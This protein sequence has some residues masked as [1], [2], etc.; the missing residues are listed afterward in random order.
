M[1]NVSV[2]DLRKHLAEGIHVGNDAPSFGDCYRYDGIKFEE[3]DDGVAIERTKGFSDYDEGGSS[4][5][6]HGRWT[7]LLLTE[8]VDATLA[9]LIR[10]GEATIDDVE[11]AT[12]VRGQAVAA[13]EQKYEDSSRRRLHFKLNQSGQPL[14]SMEIEGMHTGP[15]YL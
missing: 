1:S 15:E 7:G 14:I 13:Y 9:T 3:T 6:F 2:Q 10:E 12:S 5:S 11:I 4:E 8:V